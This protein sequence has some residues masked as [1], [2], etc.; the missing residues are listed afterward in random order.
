L[1]NKPSAISTPACPSAASPHKT[2][3]P[4]CTAVAPNATAFHTSTPRLTPPSRRIGTRPPTASEHR[5]RTSIA[6]GAVSICLPPWF[7]TTMPLAPFSTA[8]F[9]SSARQIPLR[10]TG[11]VVSER[12]RVYGG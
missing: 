1:R 2:G 11:N 5:D 3:M 7:D 9:A 10:I 12:V 8:D 6:A 4:I